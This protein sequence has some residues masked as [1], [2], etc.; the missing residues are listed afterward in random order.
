MLVR[1]MPRY[2]ESI[3]EE[4]VQSFLDS[5]FP[6]DDKDLSVYAINRESR[7]RIALER[8]ACQGSGSSPDN[9]AIRSVDLAPIEPTSEPEKTEC[10]FTYERETHAVIK[11][12]DAKGVQ[13]FGRAVFDGLKT[14]TLEIAED[15]R[16]DCEAWLASRLNAVDEEWAKFEADASDSWKK[17][18]RRVRRPATGG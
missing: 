7:I 5:E 4:N 10:R 2:R 9:K 16:A 15:S 14:G 3:A 18:F 8:K 12:R 13:A 1:F 6:A 11:L 17:L